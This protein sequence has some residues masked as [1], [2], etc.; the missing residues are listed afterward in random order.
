MFCQYFGIIARLVIAWNILGICCPCDVDMNLHMNTLSQ[1][2][3][4]LIKYFSWI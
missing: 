2:V 1:R 3:F 4:E